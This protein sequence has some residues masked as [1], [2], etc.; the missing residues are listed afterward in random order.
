MP[1]PNLFAS[2]SPYVSVSHTDL[3]VTRATRVSFPKN[4]PTHLA[5]L[6]GNATAV[7][8]GTGFLTAQSGP[9]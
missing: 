2:A 6:G 7:A 4:F 5:A 8:Q 1:P 9:A 3:R